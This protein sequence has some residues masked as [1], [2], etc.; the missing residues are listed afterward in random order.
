MPTGVG[1][2]IKVP[3]RSLDAQDVK[4]AFAFYYNY[5]EKKAKLA[6]D[7]ETTAMEAVISD[8]ASWIRI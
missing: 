2:T 7:S 5:Q 3:I 1:Y 6:K 8:L 4:D